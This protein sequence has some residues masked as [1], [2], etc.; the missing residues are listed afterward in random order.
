MMDLRKNFKRAAAVLMIAGIGFVAVAQAED[1]PT[2]PVNISALVPSGETCV[3]PEQIKEPQDPVQRYVSD[4]YRKATGGVDSSTSI[5]LNWELNERDANGNYLVGMIDIAGKAIHLNP[6]VDDRERISSISHEKRHEEQ[7]LMG[8]QTILQGNVPEIENIVMGLI[9]EVDARI[10]EIRY[11]YD[12]K[13]EG[14]PDYIETIRRSSLTR[15]MLEAFESSIN[16]DPADIPAAIRAGFLAGLET[17]ALVDH[18]ESSMI[19]KIEGHQKKFDPDRPASH[20][21]NDENLIRLGR[22][23]D[24]NYMNP[25]LM[26]AIRDLYSGQDYKTIVAM[27]KNPAVE[28]L[29]GSASIAPAAF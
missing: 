12:M 29:P 26:A 14:D 21:I 5:C 6:A 1:N 10:A 25:E 11:A 13:Q 23:G 16:T 4:I 15:Q 2:E 24:Y 27:R 22:I 20:I 8:L 19:A 3:S 18:Y 17:K 7:W 9:L 28:S